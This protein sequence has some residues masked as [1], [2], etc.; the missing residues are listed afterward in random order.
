MKN[1][2][3]TSNGDL[4]VNLVGTSNSFVEIG[5]SFEGPAIGL[6][7]F[8]IV[9]IIITHMVTQNMLIKYVEDLQLLSGHDVH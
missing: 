3:E 6:C 4:L 7:V 1:L 5:V 2:Q 9:N 8:I